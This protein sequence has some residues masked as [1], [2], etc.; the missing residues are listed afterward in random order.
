M[1]NLG[2]F[3]AWEAW[4]EGR[5]L[6]LIDPS[7]GESFSKDEVKRCIHVG[8]LC[9]QD[10]PVDRPTIL[11]A[12]SMMYSEGNQPPTP[13]Q[14]AYYFSRNRDEPEIVEGELQNFSPNN[15]SITEMEAR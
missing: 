8:L 12:L 1:R 4:N 9:G 14:P 7:L 6:E 3:Q 10:N 11:D 2:L 13:K 5:A 15:L